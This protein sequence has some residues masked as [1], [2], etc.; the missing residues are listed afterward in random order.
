MIHVTGFCFQCDSLRKESVHEKKNYDLSL[1]NC[2]SFEYRKMLE[3]LALTLLDITF[4]TT[5]VKVKYIVS[6]SSEL[7]PT[8]KETMDLYLKKMTPKLTFFVRII[9]LQFVLRRL[10]KTTYKCD[11]FKQI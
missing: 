11:Y 9:I 1:S 2:D 6:F 5:T 7:I 10:G 8:I 4:R 3:Y